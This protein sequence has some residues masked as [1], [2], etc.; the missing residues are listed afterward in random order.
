MKSKWFILLFSLFFIELVGMSSIINTEAAKTQKVV[1]KQKSCSACHDDFTNVLSEKHPP[2]KGNEVSICMK[3]HTPE[4]RGMAKSNKFDASIHL[5]HLKSP[6]NADCLDCHTFQPGKRFGLTGT[7]ES[8]G[9][10]SEEDLALI[11]EIFAS[12]VESNFLDARHFSGN[13]T[14]ASC[15]GQ[16]ILGE[17]TLE[18]TKCLSC[19]GPMEELIAKTEPKEFPDRNP[20]K[21]HLGE[22]SCTVCHLGHAESKIYCLEC[23]PKFEMKMP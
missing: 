1:E 13:I 14:C 15:H 2:V 10:L 4:E 12:A 6:I 19:H 11:K 5:T 17:N 20:H 8:Y 7:T 23:H 9:A 16:D 18:N 3:C 21:S 22:I